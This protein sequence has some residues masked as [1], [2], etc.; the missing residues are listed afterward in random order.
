MKPSRAISLGLAI[1]LA[2]AVMI[3]VGCGAGG[4]W[5]SSAPWVRGRT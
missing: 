3:V 5:C 4:A 1:V 2:M